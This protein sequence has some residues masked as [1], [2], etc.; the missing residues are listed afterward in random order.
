MKNTHTLDD[1]KISLISIWDQ[2]I[3]ILM[4]LTILSFTCC[5]SFVEVDPPNSQLIS[6]SV[7][8]EK[9]TANA[10]MT[11]IY[12]KMR[13]AGLF[14][15]NKTGLSHLFGNYTDEL[16]FYG[17]PLDA[18]VAFYNNTIVPSDPTIKSLWNSSYN[19]IYDANAII[20][21]V[22]NSVNLSSTDR[23]Q[24]KGEALF[25][26]AF[27]HFY[28]TNL[29]GNIPYVKSTD[30]QI[31]SV[32]TK[33]SATTIYK[34]CIEDLNQAIALLPDDYI[35]SDRT[36]PNKF[37]ARAFLAR[38]YLYN[39]QWNEASNEASAL[40]NNTTLY[41]FE[42]NLSKIFLKESTAT[43]WQFAPGTTGGNTLEAK[44]F[45]FTSGP[46]PISAL[47]TTLV[48]AFSPGDQ[49]KTKWISSV[50]NGSSTWY[51]PSKYKN[52]TTTISTE[53]SIVLRL[54]E[55]Y[56]IRAE[57]RAQSGDLIGS[58]EDLNI[59]RTTAGLSNTSAVSQVEILNAILNERQLEFFTE[60]GHRFFDLKRFN[61][62]DTALSGVK[63]GWNSHENT[64]P[65][66]ESEISLNK[67]L[68]PQNLG[69]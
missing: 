13:D 25:T 23:E 44:T 64:L 9:A 10:A 18:T 54:S 61:A 7:F 59:I 62:L 14:T 47:K 41:P 48:D 26:R 1:C 58:K 37:A 38:V 60:F 3:L 68:Y 36:R 56:L 28:L 42:N 66:P 40:L 20:E 52:K 69:Y 32:T 51:Y 11:Q 46:P 6:K 2:F 15:G 63:N 45:I 29:F 55:M 35:A 16:D 21:G 27:I 24:L 30:Y 8:E 34:Y 33:E 12:A 22:T 5:E 17:N 43:I 65:L 31:N 39:Q 19:Q 50:S 57:A 49:R 67:N 53:Y 4:M